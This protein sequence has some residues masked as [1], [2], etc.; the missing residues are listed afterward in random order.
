MN[1]LLINVN[2]KKFIHVLPCVT[3]PQKN[4]NRAAKGELFRNKISHFIVNKKNYLT[5]RL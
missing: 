1:F 4:S 5:D 2:V 3:I